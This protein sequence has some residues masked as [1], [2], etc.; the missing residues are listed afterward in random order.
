MY[1]FKIKELDDKKINMMQLFE[2]NKDISLIGTDTWNHPEDIH[3]SMDDLD[4]GNLTE[5]LLAN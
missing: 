3:C 4:R 2:L 1:I 5:T